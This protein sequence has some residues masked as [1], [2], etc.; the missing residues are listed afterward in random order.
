MCSWY[1]CEKR[2]TKKCHA[3]TAPVWI[4]ARYF[5]KKMKPLII[6]NTCTPKTP[7]S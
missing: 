1:R 7:H 2:S 3:P 6:Q 5:Q 4:P